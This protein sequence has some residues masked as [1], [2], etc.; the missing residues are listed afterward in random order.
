MTPSEVIESI[1]DGKYYLGTMSDIE[2][3]LEW[4]GGEIVN[5][6]SVYYEQS[7]MVSFLIKEDRLKEIYIGACKLN[8][9]SGR[10]VLPVNISYR[11]D[12]PIFQLVLKD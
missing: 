6:T 9:T 8:I 2:F 10:C 5:V 4:K 7:N 1:P 12:N 3:I 11:C